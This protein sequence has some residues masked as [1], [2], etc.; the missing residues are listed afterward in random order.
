MP[1]NP[2]LRY[3]IAVAVILIAVL[4]VVAL[5][6]L[7]GDKKADTSDFEK[8]ILSNIKAR[9]ANAPQIT[10]NIQLPEKIESLPEPAIAVV[11]IALAES[12]G[13][14]FSYVKKTGNTYS[15]GDIVLIYH[16]V[17]YLK[18]ARSSGKD[19]IGF[20][21]TVELRAPSGKIMSSLSNL[22]YYTMNAEAS[23]QN[24]YS[25]QLKSDINTASMTEKGN[26]TYIIM[27]KDKYSGKNDTKAVV[28]EVA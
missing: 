3:G 1:V 10:Q 5:F 18:P 25:V 7:M 15:E 8:I 27:V 2:S 12:I 6:M 16:K 13:A 11:N 24:Y 9:Y 28:F 14:D 21:E 26:Y 19:M 20:D 4:G 22:N 23:G 17:S